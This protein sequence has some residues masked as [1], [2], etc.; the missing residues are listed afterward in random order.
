MPPYEGKETPMLPS[1]G[2]CKAFQ[3]DFLSFKVLYWIKVDEF[4]FSCRVI[5]RASE[6]LYT[7][8]MCQNDQG[9]VN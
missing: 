3:F 6:K 2:Q 7:L 9:R 4:L 5:F 8:S 1:V